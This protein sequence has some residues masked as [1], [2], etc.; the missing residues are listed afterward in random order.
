MKRATAMFIAL[1]MLL[2][3]SMMAGCEGG[4][5]KA[6]YEKLK[7][8]A[9]QLMKDKSDLQKQVEDLTNQVNT[10]TTENEQ[11]KSQLSAAT[12]PSPSPEVSPQTGEPSE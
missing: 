7:A 12:Q 11:L 8:E 1:V 9:E 5:I 4:R 6:E 10:L 2:S 3:V